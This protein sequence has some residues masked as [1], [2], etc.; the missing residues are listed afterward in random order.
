MLS[1]LS[2][3]GSQR[4][5]AGEPPLSLVIGNSTQVTLQFRG[6]VIDLAPYTKN[7]VARLTVE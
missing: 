4:E 1:E 3:A 7:G 6:K 2:A 5:I